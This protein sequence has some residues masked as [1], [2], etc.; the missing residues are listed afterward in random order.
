MV[1]RGRR[2]GAGFQDHVL[3]SVRV[4]QAGIETCNCVC[5]SIS[6]MGLGGWWLAAMV[7]FFVPSGGKGYPALFVI[8][9][10]PV[11]DI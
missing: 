7:L 5:G 9:F 11:S 2:T 3:S 6:L 1:L 4:L 10:L 8:F